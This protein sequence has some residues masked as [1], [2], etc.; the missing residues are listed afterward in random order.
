VH[1]LER[2]LAPLRELQLEQRANE[3]VVDLD[4]AVV[5]LL[6]RHAGSVS[7]TDTATRA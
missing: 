5:H 4:L 1:L 2:Q 3:R 6:S 7:T